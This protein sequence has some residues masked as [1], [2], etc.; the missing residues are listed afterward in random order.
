MSTPQQTSLLL[1]LQ[2]SLP[3]IQTLTDL[4]LSLLP[5]VAQLLA[6]AASSSPLAA[7]L[8]AAARAMKAAWPAATLPAW[9]PHALR[10]EACRAAAAAQ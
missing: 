3:V 5:A 7:A 1:L 4:A 2:P 8:L 10:A 6:A 9:P